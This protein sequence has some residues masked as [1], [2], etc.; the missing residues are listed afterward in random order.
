M[1]RISQIRESAIKLPARFTFAGFVIYPSLLNFTD[2]FKTVS[3][4]NLK[5]LRFSPRALNARL[6]LHSYRS[7]VRLSD[8]QFHKYQ[9]RFLF[10]TVIY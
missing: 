1:G 3:L 10:L 4:V 7:V 6:F 5:L 2:D 9:I 8:K